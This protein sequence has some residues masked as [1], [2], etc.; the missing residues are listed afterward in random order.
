MSFND[1]AIVT[2]RGNYYR[3]NFRFMTE[4]KAVDRN[5]NADLGKKKYITMIIRKTITMII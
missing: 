5:K 2:V 3:V 4:N 1:F